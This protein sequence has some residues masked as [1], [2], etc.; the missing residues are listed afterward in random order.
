MWSVMLICAEW[1]DAANGPGKCC[2][3]DS[4][5]GLGA[6]VPPTPTPSPQGWCLLGSC[7][8]D[9]L[10]D[11][12][13]SAS[14][15]GATLL[16]AERSSFCRRSLRVK[17]TGEGVVSMATG[18]PGPDFGCGELWAEMLTAEF[19]LAES[20]GA[21]RSWLGPQSHCRSAPEPMLNISAQW[22]R[23]SCPGWRRCGRWVW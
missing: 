2:I 19:V 10:F 7:F 15:S 14:L 6:V 8:R 5:E 18:L 13:R 22:R 1:P 11:S 16:P 23:A 21:S 20:W 3:A 9:E 4:C 12:S 17:L